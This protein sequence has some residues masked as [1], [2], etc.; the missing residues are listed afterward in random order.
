MSDHEAVLKR[1]LAILAGAL[2]AALTPP[3][4][5]LADSHDAS[6]ASRVE[7]A[8][9][10]E[11][12]V[13]ADFKHTIAGGLKAE[14]G[15]SDWWSIGSMAYVGTSFNTG[16]TTSILGTLDDEEPPGDP[17]PT[18]SEFEGGLTEIPR[19]GAAYV[20]LT[21]VRGVFE[22]FGQPLV[23]Y[24]VYVSGGVSVGRTCRPRSPRE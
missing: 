3:A 5:A 21:P 20:T 23:A 11:T 19:H 24:D 9:T 8:L 16:L 7:L 14:F 17:T 22:A 1:V 6:I 15:L 4:V 2:G 10:F 18:R 13:N 12:S